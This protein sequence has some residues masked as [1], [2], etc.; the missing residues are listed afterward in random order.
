MAAGNTNVDIHALQHRLQLLEQEN[1][2]LKRNNATLQKAGELYKGALFFSAS[3]AYQR[4]A[5]SQY[6]KSPK[7]IM[8]NGMYK[9]TMAPKGISRQHLYLKAMQQF[10][11]NQAVNLVADNV[12]NLLQEA[13]LRISKLMNVIYQLRQQLV[14]KTKEFDECKKCTFCNDTGFAGDFPTTPMHVRRERSSDECSQSSPPQ[15]DCMRSL[16]DTPMS[17]SLHDLF[18][19]DSLCFID[20][21]DSVQVGTPDTVLSDEDDSLGKGAMTRLY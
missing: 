21:C 1:A 17:Q 8:T 18:E 11:A 13:T 7:S 14:E 9:A 10:Y 2:L 5:F 3:E 19:N 20:D 6:I 15:G 4:H 12:T 16:T